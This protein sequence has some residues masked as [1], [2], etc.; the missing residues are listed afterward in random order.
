M[1]LHKYTIEPGDELLLTLRNKED[2][3]SMYRQVQRLSG[4]FLKGWGF[5]AQEIAL[6]PDHLTLL[7]KQGKRLDILIAEEA[8]SEIGK[9]ID[10]TELPTCV[11]LVEDASLD[12]FTAVARFTFSKEEAGKLALELLKGILTELQQDT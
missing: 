11:P 1:C 9:L 3:T 8:A 12:L 5:W 7:K 2:E 4:L 10:L 6:H